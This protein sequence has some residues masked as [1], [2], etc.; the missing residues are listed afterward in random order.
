MLAYMQDWVTFGLLWLYCSFGCWRAQNGSTNL[1]EY[2]KNSLGLVQR[3]VFCLPPMWCLAPNSIFPCFVASWSVTA[4][5]W[6]SVITCCS[7]LLQGLRA[8]L[9]LVVGKFCARPLW[10]GKASFTLNFLPSFFLL[11]FSSFTLIQLSWPSADSSYMSRSRNAWNLQ[12][13][14]R[15]T[16]LRIEKVIGPMLRS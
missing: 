15:Y 1:L 16:A 13:S 9:Q 14:L 12:E 6:L 11:W 3:T 2:R 7:W 4:C 5:R 8:H 10:N